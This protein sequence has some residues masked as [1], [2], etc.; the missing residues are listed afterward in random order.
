MCA[1][2]IC[3]TIVLAFSLTKYKCESKSGKIIL[4]KYWKSDLS[5][6]QTLVSV[7]CYVEFWCDKRQFLFNELRWKYFR[8]ELRINTSIFCILWPIEFLKSWFFS[9]NVQNLPVAHS[10]LSSS[11]TWKQGK[12]TLSLED[13]YFYLTQD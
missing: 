12:W 5:T 3:F 2:Q 11:V 8:D 6:D 13:V 1:K 4:W 10:S 9:L 7:K